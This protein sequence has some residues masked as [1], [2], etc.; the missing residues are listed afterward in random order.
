MS[1]V[2]D[3]SGVVV[4]PFNNA[5]DDKYGQVSCLLKV[6]DL[7]ASVPKP[8]EIADAYYCIKNGHLRVK[9]KGF[10]DVPDMKKDDEVTLKVQ[11][12]SWKMADGKEG[13][14]AFLV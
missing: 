13:I 3:I 7:P 12:K 8:L 1:V 5:K 2:V 11:F 9:V 10:V 4:Y 6:I 14:S